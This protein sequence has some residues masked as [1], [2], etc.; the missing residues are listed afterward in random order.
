MQRYTDQQVIELV[1]VY[2]HSSQHPDQKVYAA[3]FFK[4]FHIEEDGGAMYLAT[5]RNLMRLGKMQDCRVLEAGC[6]LGWDAVTIAMLGNN[7]VVASDIL[8]SMIE[9]C[10]ESVSALKAKGAD[11]DVT[12]MVGDIC[13]IELEPASFDVICSIEA[14]EHVH[15]LERMFD[16][17][18]TLL[19]PGG[20]IVI[21]NDSNRYNLQFR[22]DT[23]KMWRERDRSW[24]HMAFLRTVRPVEHAHSKPYAAMREEIVRQAN[25]SI[26]DAHCAAIVDATAGMIRPDISELSLSYRSGATLPTPPPFSWCRNPETGEYAE[27][28]L[29]PFEIAEMLTAR[30]FRRARVLHAFRR[31]PIRYLNSIQFRPLNRYLFNLRPSFIVTAHKALDA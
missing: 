18:A 28:L 11:F 2:A 3:S 6:G 25:P 31:F 21:A 1:K 30:G 13:E 22:D 7:E 8:A 5:M 26:L 12:P 29:D 14:I 20:R 24:E 16:R 17:C 23:F 4:S 9:G 19:R 15:S 27:R 10:A